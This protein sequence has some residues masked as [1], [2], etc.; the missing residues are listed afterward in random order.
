MRGPYRQTTLANAG[1]VL[2]GL[3]VQGKKKVLYTHIIYNSLYTLKLML[4]AQLMVF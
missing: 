3:N 2:E 4:T 1:P